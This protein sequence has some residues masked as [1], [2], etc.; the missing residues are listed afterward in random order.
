MK[1]KKIELTFNHCSN[2][3]RFYRTL[4]A[5]ED[6][7]L[8]DLGCAIATAI[9][10][11]FEHCFLFETKDKNFMPRAFMEDF[12]MSNDVLMDNYTLLDLGTKFEYTY[13]TGDGYDFTGK[14]SNTDKEYVEGS[15]DVILI[16]GAGQ[17]VWED[18]IHSLCSYLNGKLKADDVAS[19]E[20]PFPWNFQIEKFGDF[21]TEFNLE[22]EK[23]SFQSI[24]MADRELYKENERKYFGLE[25]DD[26]DEENSFEEESQ[27]ILTLFTSIYDATMTFIKELIKKD[28]YCKDVYNKLLVNHK[29]KEAKELMCKE[30]V[31]LQLKNAKKGIPSV[32]PKELTKAFNKLVE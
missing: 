9:G 31:F 22:E 25:E 27:Q 16:D 17:G 13:D 4:L 6:I 21:D 15:D 24:Y 28:P 30:Y 3:K 18:N 10:T 8:T 29:P 11:M 26:E 19:E 14:V 12:V 2:K 1:Y 7:N 5:K 20:Y 23:E 32:G